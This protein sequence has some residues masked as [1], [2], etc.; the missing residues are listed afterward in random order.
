VS[1]EFH[2]YRGYRFAVRML[3]TGGAWEVRIDPLDALPAVAHTGSA[4]SRDEALVSAKSIVDDA[5]DR[6]AARQHA[7]RSR[8]A[9][10][11]L[12]RLL[13]RFQMGQT[14]MARAGR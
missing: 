7:A 1:Q 5:Y 11:P 14:T 12:A 8:F 13:G 6:I 9:V 2:T 3:K 4:R 10:P